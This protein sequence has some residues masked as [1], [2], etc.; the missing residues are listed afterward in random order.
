MFFFE[1]WR[2]PSPR[3]GTKSVWWVQAKCKTF[4]VHSGVIGIFL[5]QCFFGGHVLASFWGACFETKGLT[6]VSSFPPSGLHPGTFPKPTIWL[7]PFPLYPP[8][9][10][11]SLATIRPVFVCAPFNMIAFT[12]FINLQFLFP[13]SFLAMLNGSLPA[14]FCYTSGTWTGPLA[15]IMLVLF[16]VHAVYAPFPYCLL[17]FDVPFTRYQEL[18]Q[19]STLCQSR[20]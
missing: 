12:L 1:E 6:E 9:P 11:P 7:S 5:R 18:R 15:K 20:S 4:V 17:L 13:L 8:H 16:C 10:L 2:W 3:R 14:A 19:W